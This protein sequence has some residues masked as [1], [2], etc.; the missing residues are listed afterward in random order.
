MGK[1]TK[2]LFRRA[3]DFGDSIDKSLSNLLKIN[4]RYTLKIVL[5]ISFLYIIVG[6]LFAYSVSRSDPTEAGF[7]FGFLLLS[8]FFALILLIFAAIVRIL[9]FRKS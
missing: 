3:T 2:D 8:G 6:L 1:S 9:V 4:F 7:T 5:L